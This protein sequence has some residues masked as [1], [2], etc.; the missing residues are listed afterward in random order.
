MEG[1]GSLA[2]ALAV[3]RLLRAVTAP[4]D[5]AQVLALFAAHLP[6]GSVVMMLVGP[7]VMSFGWQALWLINGA[8][9]LAYAA[10]I[11]RMRIDEATTAHAAP[12]SVLTNIGAVLGAPGPVLLALAFGT[13]TFQ[14][15]A[16][17]GLLPAL[18][19]DR[20]G[21]SIAAAGTISAI[22][23]A[24][25]AA[26]NMSAGALLRWGVPVWSILAGAFAFVGRGGGRHLL[27]CGAGRDGCGAGGAEPRADRADPG[28]DLCGGAAACADLGDARD[29][30]R[31]DQPG[32]Q[33]RKSRRPGGDGVH[34][35]VGWAGA[36]RRCC[37]PASR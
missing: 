28:I 2:A 7:H 17:A 18:L 29:R 20:M 3:P 30:A 6:F 13:Y 10:V 24:A 1:C 22:A 9:A 16:L 11:A 8:V 31:P 32:D 35:R 4:K 12:P 15:L 37:L 5:L 26:G 33:S 23:V 27:R 19:V 25:N 21:L 36:A 34:R 14:Y